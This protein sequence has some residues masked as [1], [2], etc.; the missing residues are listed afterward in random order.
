W[1][2]LFFDEG[3]FQKDESKSDEWNRGAY[4]VQGLGHC[5]GCHTPKNALGGDKTSLAYSGGLLQGWFAPAITANPRYGVGPWSED[6]IVE[7]LQTGHNRN[8]AATGPMAEV[9]ENST[10]KMTR[11]DL[12]AMAIYLKSLEDQPESSP[13]APD[14]ALMTSGRTLYEDNCTA[15]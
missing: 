9:V 10:S 14:Q 15:C 4:L 6:D 3:S 1:N 8:A 11:S 7:S 2:A 13:A 12:H 5:S